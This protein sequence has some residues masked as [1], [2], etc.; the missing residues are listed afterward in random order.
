VATQTGVITAKLELTLYLVDCSV[1]MAAHPTVP[2]QIAQQNA[3]AT[4]L[5]EIN[6]LTHR[7]LN[8]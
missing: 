6:N 5:Y 7:Y 3:T 4:D 2:K 8:N 1:L